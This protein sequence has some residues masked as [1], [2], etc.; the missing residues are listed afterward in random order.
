M[1][2]NTKVA[3]ELFSN[4]AG[5]SLI[6]VSGG[7]VSMPPVFPPPVASNSTCNVKLPE[8]PSHSYMPNV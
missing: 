7:I 3:D 8:K 2:L 4:A 1:E 5:E 6:L